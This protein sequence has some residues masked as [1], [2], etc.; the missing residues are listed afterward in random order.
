MGLLENMRN[1]KDEIQDDDADLAHDILDRIE[2]SARKHISPT[3]VVFASI[4]VLLILAASLFIVAW[5][6][7][8]DR[9]TVDVVY[10]QGGPGHVVL[11]E[12]GNDGSRTIENVDLTIRFVDSDGI[13]VGRQDFSRDSLS[14]HTSVSGDELELL[15]DGASVWENYTIEIILYYDSYDSDRSERWT[16]N[17][18]EW[19]MQLFFDRSSFHFL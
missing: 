11:V 3:R 18:G 5:V 10:R 17:V 15:I 14:P 8:Y 16:H 6:V 9:V 7:P 19:T 2:E 1:Q 12:L 13:E 4:S